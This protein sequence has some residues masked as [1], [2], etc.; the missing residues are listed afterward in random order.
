MTPRPLFS[1]LHDLLDHDRDVRLGELL[2]AAGEQSYGLLILL[3]AL[4]SLVPALNT[5]LAPVGGAAVMAIGYQLGK[6]VPHPWVPQR[7]LALPI[8]KGAVKHALARL[9]GLLLRWSSRTAERHPLSRRWMGA[10]LVWTGFL[11]ALPVPLPFANIIPAAV[12]CLLGAA[13]MEQ[14]QDWA[15]AATF[16]SLGTTLYFALSANLAFRIAKAI[17]G[18]VN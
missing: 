7:I 17:R 18:L 6:G 14:R 13:V 8:H 4:P 3:L 10:A 15:W 11:L 2:D 16:A 9:E 1:V 5:G 12:L